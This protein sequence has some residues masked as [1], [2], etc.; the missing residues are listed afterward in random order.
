MKFLRTPISPFCRWLAFNS[1]GA[2]G[3]VVQMGMLFLLVGILDL[4]YLLATT[5]AVETA[6]L[7]NFFWHE[8]WTWADR[9]N[10]CRHLWVR[11]LVYFHLAN[12]MFSLLGNLVLMRLFVGVMGM[13][14]ALANPIAICLCAIMNYLAGD[15]FVFRAAGKLS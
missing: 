1:V 7:H 9:A 8:N 15:R 3:I 11:R 2:L 10:A 4:N 13:N 5:I 12:G 6:V 14:Y